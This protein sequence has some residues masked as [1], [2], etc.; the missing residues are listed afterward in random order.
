MGKKRSKTTCK[1]RKAKAA[2]HHV[3]ITVAKR[4]NTAII[5]SSTFGEKNHGSIDKKTVPIQTQGGLVARRRTKPSQGGKRTPQSWMDKKKEK[6]ITSLSKGDDEQRSFSRELAS[7]R[8]R[9]GATKQRQERCNKIVLEPA[10]LKLEPVTL[11][12]KILDAALRVGKAMSF[13]EADQHNS[14]NNDNSLSA[15]DSH[16]GDPQQWWAKTEKTVE[17]KR[18]NNPW[19]VLGTGDSSSDEDEHSSAVQ[20]NATNGIH[21]A[22][23][24]QST[25]SARPILFAPPT[26]QFKSAF[27]N[28]SLAPDEASLRQAS[29]A[30]AT[31]SV[32]ERSHVFDIDPDL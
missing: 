30:I 2:A 31:L 6:I 18:A 20:S 8:E 10:V 26:F 32:C 25:S 14:N 21:T 11:Q 16:Y 5:S 19:S 7:L 9:V 29:S 23:P 17:I 12:E 3:K 28:S 15:V 4:T 1:Q 22:F 27:E 24:S 13:G